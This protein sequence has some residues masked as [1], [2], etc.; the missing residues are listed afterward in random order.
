MLSM[1][2]MFEN[3]P[4]S[5]SMVKRIHILTAAKV[6]DY[7]CCIYA[8]CLLSGELSYRSIQLQLQCSLHVA[9]QSS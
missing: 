6:Y 4:T 3:E 9:E 8:L 1:S 5:V 2:T 7:V